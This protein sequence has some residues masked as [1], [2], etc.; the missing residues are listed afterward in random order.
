MRERESGF[1]IRKYHKL[2]KNIDIL[3]YSFPCQDLSQQGRQK[4][5]KSGTRSGLLFEIERILNENKGNLPKILLLENVKA[6]ASKKF[7]LEFNSWIKKLEEFGYTSSWKIINSTEYGSVQNRERVFMVS[8]LERKK[9][10]FPIGS[11][12]NKNVKD[13]WL[14]ND[15][16]SFLK[17]ND[18]NYINKF[19]ISKNNIIK[20]FINNWSNFNSENY[21]YSLEGK[22][23]T[24]TASGANSRLKFLINNEIQIMNSCE[25]YLYMGFSKNDFNVVKETNL[26]TDSKII[27]TAGNSISIEVLEKIFEKIIKDYF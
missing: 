6:L 26:L 8:V 15:K 17:L 5:I 4:G 2:P 9:F 12:N 3:T 18:N 27:F 23:P 10:D 24:L 25:A 1:D 14:K 19:T 21:I 22:G 13:I 20:S 16:H 11:K 7:I